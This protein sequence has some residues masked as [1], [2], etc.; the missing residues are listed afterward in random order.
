MHSRIIFFCLAI[1]IALFPSKATGV[2][3]II[4]LLPELQQPNYFEITDF[5]QRAAPQLSGPVFD[6]ILG[7]LDFLSKDRDNGKPEQ[8]ASLITL[9]PSSYDFGS[10]KVNESSRQIIILTNNSK[11]KL[12]LRDGDPE[13]SAPFSYAGGTYPGAGGTCGKK[14]NK[15]SS[16]QV[17][18]QFSPKAGGTFAGSLAIDVSEKDF[19]KE[20]KHRWFEWVCS[21]KKHWIKHPHCGDDF[22]T[23]KASLKGVGGAVLSNLTVGEEVS[24]DFQGRITGT[25]TLKTFTLKNVSDVDTTDLNVYLSPVA[26][27]SFAGGAFPGTGGSCGASL[28]ANSNC[29]FVVAFSPTAAGSSAQA[30]EISA[31]NSLSKASY[32]VIGL[33][34][35]PLVSGSADVSYGTASVAVSDSGNS[36]EMLTSVAVVNDKIVGGGF[37]YSGGSNDFVASVQNLSGAADTSFN[38]TGTATIDLGHNSND[39]VQAVLPVSNGGLVLAGYSDNYCAAVKLTSIGALDTSYNGNGKSLLGW[40]GDSFC[41]SAVLDANENSILVGT[42]N[43]SGDYQ[44]AIVRLTQNGVLD[45]SFNGTGKFFLSMGFGSSMAFSGAVQANGK[46]LAAGFATANS[47]TDEVIIRLN[48][49]GSVDSSFGYSGGMWLN[50]GGH[51]KATHVIT[52]PDGKILVAGRYTQFSTSLYGYTLARLN[53]NGMPDTTFGTAGK[54]LSSLA[55]ADSTNATVAVAPSGEYYVAWSRYLQSNPSQNTVKVSKFSA[56]GQLV[57]S[58]G[59]NGTMNLTNVV[60]IQDQNPAL[61]IMSDGRVIVGGA[62]VDKT[63]MATTRVW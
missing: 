22:Q 63:N 52:Q 9:S 54:Y 57:D 8:G 26:P 55:E 28:K 21:K 44:F 51:E 43:T 59:V 18:V 42:T 47:G 37:A 49:D 20:G 3:K 10:V 6:F 7:L 29:N 36:Q 4:T 17:V 61:A 23:V 14:L 25:T 32:Q 31:S 41:Y 62:T 33:G 38:S 40:G 58:F 48:P 11:D 45:T 35:V 30:I 27:F 13:L 39:V 60:S 56:N 1:S 12:S 16:C 50:W 15:K 46:I 19:E 2:K 24:H 53:P 34:I 5:K